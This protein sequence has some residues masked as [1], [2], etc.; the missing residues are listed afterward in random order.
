VAAVT[1]PALVAVDPK[2]NRVVAS[3]PVGSR[4]AS[5][6][7][8]D[9]SVWVGDA[10]DGTVTRI[11]PVTRTAVKTIG[12]AAPAIDLAAGDGSIWAATGGFGT[13]VRIDPR[14]NEVASRI[15]LGS[16]ADPVVPAASAVAEGGGQLWV[17][18]F[19]GLAEFD[20]DSGRS[21]GKVDL[22]RAPAHQIA[23]GNG[24]VWA[25]LDTSYA[26]AVDASSRRLTAQFYAGTGVFAITLDTSAVW[27]SGEYGGQLWKL[28]PRTGATIRTGNAG[29]GATGIALGFGAVWIASWP[30]H[31]LVRVDP[32]TGNVL[33]TI[34]TGGEPE[35][36]AIG[37]GLVWVVVQRAPINS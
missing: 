14:A 5:V 6:A 1:A 19:D 3:I 11:D 23:L 7:F 15:D 9:G 29:K 12:I 17:G 16:P 28:D 4:P 27:L 26:K 18:A 25:S 30:D 20:P 13:I 34:S 35:D 33:A 36:I 21:K 2:T 10:A 31:T 32:A 8:G 22:G 37:D 24:T